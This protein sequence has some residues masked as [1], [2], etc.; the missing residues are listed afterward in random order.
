MPTQN[1]SRTALI[2][3][4][5]QN[6]YFEKGNWPLQNQE[7]AAQKAQ[8]LLAHCRKNGLPVIH[9]QHL[10]GKADAPFFAQGTSGAEIHN[11]VSPQ[12][13]EPVIVKSEINGFKNTEL[14][15]LLRAQRVT[16]LIIA[17]S[18]SH[19]CIDALTR[20][21]SDYGFECVVAEDSCATRDL[22]FKGTTVPAELVHA[23]FMSALGFAYAEILSSE[24]ALRHLE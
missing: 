23:A 4:D 21:A 8:G 11:S 5:L 9:I 24:E 2:L 20:A 10:S 6:D 18:M 16:K 22:E 13:N 7:Q 1:T 17:G 3:V 12:E 15:D 19:M 14:L